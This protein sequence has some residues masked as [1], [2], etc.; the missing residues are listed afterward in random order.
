MN[1]QFLRELDRTLSKLSPLL[2]VQRPALGWISTIRTALGMTE[3]QL[4]E[5][6]DVPP[7]HIS[8]IER[9]ELSGNAS[10]ETM[11]RVA[12]ALNCRFVYALVPIDGL[13]A[14]LVR[15]ARELAKA[16]LEYVNHQMR[17]EGQQL[18]EDDI[19]R[20]VQDDIAE[21]LSESS[22]ALWDKPE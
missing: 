9:E 2:R 5:R 19:E 20:L 6:V 17:L 22:S 21:M 16:R 8:A 4:A 14:S 13:E 12:A 15:R 11:G 18:S 3:R 1:M 7:N 10:L